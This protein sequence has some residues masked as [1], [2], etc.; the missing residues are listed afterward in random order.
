M[1]L[2]MINRR[3]LKCDRWFCRLASASLLL[4]G[5][6]THAKADPRVDTAPAAARAAPPEP[7]A[8]PATPVH[9]ETI[10]EQQGVASW[11]GRHWRGRR[12]ASGT[13]FDDRALTA[14]HLWLP[15]ATRAHVTNLQN[16]RSVDVVVTDRGPYHDGRIIDLSHRAAALIGILQ[17]GV[18][19]VAITA[20]WPSAANAATVTGR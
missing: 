15:F 6:L 5:A 4:I 10:V 8:H 3:I 2:A 20:L 13:R 14:A 12:T 11:Y 1:I 17:T 7:S 9:G 18:A 19:K 16:G